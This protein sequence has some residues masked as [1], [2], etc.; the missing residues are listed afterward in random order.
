MM[1]LTEEE[2]GRGS[3]GSTVKTR[4]KGDTIT[5]K[6]IIGNIGDETGKMFR[7]THKYWKVSITLI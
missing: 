5:M 1:N 4:F 2:L 7:K 6:K 3:F